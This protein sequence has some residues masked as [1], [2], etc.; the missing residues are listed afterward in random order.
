VGA[1]EGSGSAVAAAAA[2]ATARAGSATGRAASER[3]RT[4]ES[5][6]SYG[7]QSPHAEPCATNTDFAYRTNNQVIPGQRA[8]RKGSC[9]FLSIL[10]GL[11]GDFTLLSRSYYYLRRRSPGPPFPPDH[12]QA[13]ERGAKIHHLRACDSCLPCNSFHVYPSLPSR[14]ANEPW[15]THLVKLQHLQPLRRTCNHEGELQPR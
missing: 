8:S 9:I 6:C 2:V 14:R 4:T 5:H 11:Y 3:A 7:M 12:R 13:G 10:T 1:E 15:R